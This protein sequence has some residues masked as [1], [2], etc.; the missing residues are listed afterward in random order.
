MTKV[1]TYLVNVI[2][3]FNSPRS[4]KHLRDDLAKEL[5]F[6]LW[7]S[8]FNWLVM[9]VNGLVTIA[10][11]REPQPAQAVR[12]GCCVAGTHRIGTRS[13]WWPWRLWAARTA[14]ARPSGA[15]PAQSGARAAEDGA[16]VRR[17][18]RAARRDTTPAAD[19]RRPRVAAC[20]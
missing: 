12:C 19:T 20:G 3:L 6:V 13:W 17:P 7:L 8:F 15:C 11:H 5:F 14:A 2:S 16:R 1:H 9:L 18:A 10:V 4:N